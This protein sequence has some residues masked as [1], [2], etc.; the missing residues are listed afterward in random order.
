V[1][2]DHVQSEQIIKRYIH[3]Y[4]YQLFLE[5]AAH[6]PMLNINVCVGVQFYETLAALPT[7]VS[8]FALQY[9]S[10]FNGGHQFAWIAVLV[11]V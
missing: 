7:S 6:V 3:M 5:Q 2:A 9:F 11:V 1:N 10:N 4:V 8:P